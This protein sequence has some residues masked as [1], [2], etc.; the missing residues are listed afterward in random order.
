[1]KYP[2]TT[3]REYL[4]AVNAGIN[5]AYLDLGFNA[6]Q[7]KEMRIGLE[8]GLNINV[9]TNPEISATKMRTARLLQEMGTQV[10]PDLLQN[11]HERQLV[12]IRLGN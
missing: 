11:Y 10:N 1:M 4:K 7:F 3:L 8:H 6:E 2:T 9:Y 5:P 12:V